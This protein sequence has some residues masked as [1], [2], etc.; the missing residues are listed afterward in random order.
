M[1]DEGQAGLAQ[2]PSTRTLDVGCIRIDGSALW[3]DEARECELAPFLAPMSLE[4]LMSDFAKEPPPQAK[5]KVP[6]GRFGRFGGV[7]GQINVAGVLAAMRGVVAAQTGG[8]GEDGLSEA[9]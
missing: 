3:P 8:A 6:K 4:M 7:G 5:A 9:L 2:A 1:T